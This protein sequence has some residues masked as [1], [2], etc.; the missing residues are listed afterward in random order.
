MVVLLRMAAVLMVLALT[1]PG[2]M[3]PMAQVHTA[4]RRIPTTIIM[5]CLPVPVRTHGVATVTSSLEDAFSTP[6]SSEGRRST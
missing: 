6:I 2:R 4:I 5:A 1:A 3:V